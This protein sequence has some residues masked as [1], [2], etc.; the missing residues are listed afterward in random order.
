LSIQPVAPSPPLEG[1]ALNRFVQQWLADVLVG[2]LDQT[3]IRPWTQGEPPVIP[4]EATAWMA[5]RQTV[6]DGDTFAYARA[7]S[8]G[9]GVTMNRQERL[10]V[11]CSFYDLG[12]EGLAE[13][14]ASLLRDNL[15]ITDNLETLFL[16]NFGMVGCGDPVTIPSLLKERWLYRV[17][18]P[19]RLSRSVTRVYAVPNITSANGT[20]NTDGGLSP[21][22]INTEN[23]HT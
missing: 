3:L 7:N 17:D 21:V 11:L 20:L 15:S 16:A 23:Q 9:S 10:D 18:L 14:L 22:A 19:F 13:G 4:Q 1:Q 2:S 6:G 5:F 12:T 8:D